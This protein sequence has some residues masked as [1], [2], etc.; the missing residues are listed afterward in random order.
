MNTGKS[1]VIVGSS[2][3]KIIVST[4]QYSCGACGK[5]CRKTLLSTQYVKRGFTCVVVVY[6]VYSLSVV[7]DGLMCKQCHGNSGS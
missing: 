2:G 1:K 3:R 6:V 4:E 5:Q 7:V